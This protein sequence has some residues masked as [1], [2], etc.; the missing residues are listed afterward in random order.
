MR[1]LYLFCCLFLG[2]ISAF[3][4][5]QYYCPAANAPFFNNLVNLIGSIHRYNYDHLEEIAVFDLGMTS[6]QCETLKKM[7]KVQLYSLK[8]KNPALLTPFKIP[9]TTRIF[10]GWYAWKPVAI[11][12]S[13]E[14]FPYVLWMDAGC[15]VKKPLDA[16]FAY[17]QREGYFLNTIGDEENEKGYAHSV[18]WGVTD[19]VR[20]KFK[21]TKPQFRWILEK[22]SVMATTFGLSKASKN[23]FLKE[24]VEM[25][26]DMRH[27]A[28]NGS[29]PGG[30]GACRHDQSLLSIL[31]YQKQLKVHKI[32]YSQKR[33]IEIGT[34]D[35]KIP[36]YIT[37]NKDCMSDLTSVLTQDRGL[38]QYEQNVKN[39]RTKKD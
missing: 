31:A 28:D 6:E 18:G 37:W 8:D 2:K 38:H 23:L 10:L 4:I 35:Q 21:L 24:W 16:L 25:T 9:T 11:Y 7:S 34:K 15:T 32:D 17:I 13:L 5:P 30:W 19:F 12:E 36:F 26:K 3:A 14:K 1:A 27:F 33:S 20:N 29:C 39:I 22:E